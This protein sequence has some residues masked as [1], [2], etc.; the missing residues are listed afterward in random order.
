LLLLKTTH[1][2]PLEREYEAWIVAGIE[3]HFDRL[4]I[5][6]AIWGVSPNVEATWPAD[7]RLSVAGKIVGLQFKQAKLGSGPVGFDRL[8]WSLHQPRGQFE[9]V[10]ANPEIF[11]CLPT[12]ANRV[13]RSEALS[14]CLFWR[15]GEEVN[16][17]AWYDNS[18][19]HTP[20]KQLRGAMRWG[21]FLEALY[22]CTA[23]VR[24][25]GPEE[26]RRAVQRIYART[27]EFINPQGDAN[28]ESELGLYLLFVALDR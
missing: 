7:E 9:L 27:T 10:Q 23:G 18:A 4:K 28:A 19:A 13:V 22:S 26:A 3:R 16:Y 1:T 24:T 15:P 25:V 21:A 8:K 12:F 6:F 2:H 5:D 20:Y 14:H 17:N 11:Y